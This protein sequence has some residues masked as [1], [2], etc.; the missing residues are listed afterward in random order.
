MSSFASVTC[1][2]RFNSESAGTMQFD[3]DPTKILIVGMSGA[4]K[5]TYQ[6]RY[7][8]NTPYDRI[9]IFDHKLEFRAKLGVDTV[10]STDDIVRKLEEGK[11]KMFSYSPLEDY[12]G[13]QQLGFNFY[14]EWTYNVCKALCA[15]GRKSLFVADEV[16]R[17]TDSSNMGDE[18]RELI[19]D[20]R[21]QGLDFIGTSH[22]ANSINNK[23]RGQLS[24]IVA[25]R[26]RD[27][28]PLK[29][30]EENGFDPEEVRALNK[31]EFIS[32][33]CAND[34][35]TRS[36]LFSCPRTEKSVEPESETSTIPSRNTQ[37]AL[38]S[39]PADGLPDGVESGP[40]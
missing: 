21:L 2:S 16:N 13:D 35:F 27:A 8:K 24:E 23:L 36:K 4:G 17:F 15:D 9:F 30:L 29:F 32:L 34:R 11:E 7:V 40:Q 37:H 12:P 10:F 5:S 26:T 3:H 18:F 6:I 19:E 38:S 25:L 31:G 33:D 20:G 28:R 14:C 39:A 1:S 22:G